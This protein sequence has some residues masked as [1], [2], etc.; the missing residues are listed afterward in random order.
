MLAVSTSG[1]GIKILANADGVRLFRSIESR[2]GDSSRVPS[3]T[4]AKVLLF[5]QLLY[6]LQ[7][8]TCL[9]NAFFNFQGPI[10]SSFAGSGSTHGTNIVDGDRSAP[11][12]MMGGLVSLMPVMSIIGIFLCK[13]FNGF[14]I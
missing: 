5:F 4:V 7:L 12:T 8:C 14:G 2:A 10:M 11:L 3:A 13:K 6:E 9:L 1:N